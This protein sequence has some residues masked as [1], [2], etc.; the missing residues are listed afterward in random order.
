[1]PHFAVES[2]T[3]KSLSYLTERSLLDLEFRD[4]AVYRF[5]D[6]PPGCLEQLLASDSKGAYF[7]L[8]I[9]NRFRH[10]RVSGAVSNSVRSDTVAGKT[11]LPLPVK[12]N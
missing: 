9:R 10:Q 1:M 8:R 5:F 3:L 2:T 12:E 6:V 4:G 7:N 11:T